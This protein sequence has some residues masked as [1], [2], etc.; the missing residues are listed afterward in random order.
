MPTTKTKLYGIEAPAKLFPKIIHQLRHEF[1]DIKTVLDIGAGSGRFLKYF[2]HGVYKSPKGVWVND[3][4]PQL[5]K[6]IAIEPYTRFCEQLRRLSNGV[7]EVVCKPWE[8]VRDV[9]LR[10]VHD[11]VILWDVAMFIDLR[12]VY[13]VEDPA[14]ALI[15]E[16]DRIISAT[17]R[18][19]LFSLHHVRHC[20]ICIADFQRVLSYLDS[21]L[22]VRAVNRWNRVYE[23]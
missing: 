19:F 7:V 14:E 1:R 4:K 2:V 18:W 17:K 10:D 12:E 21:K 20:V 8:D 6:Y 3:A 16:L 13:G 5:E 11:M 23:V 15:C 22:K 9:Y